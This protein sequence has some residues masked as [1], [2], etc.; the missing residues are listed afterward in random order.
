M[1]L[2]KNAK[3][4][5]PVHLIPF[6]IYKRKILMKQYFYSDFRPL[7]TIG[8]SLLSYA[9]SIL[10]LTFMVEILRLNWCKQVRL[11]KTVDAFIPLTGGFLGGFA[12]LLESNTRYIHIKM[13]SL[14]N[15]V[16]YC[17]KIFRNTC[18]PD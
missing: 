4:Y 6:I 11:R 17:A 9:K 14:R 1:L 16:E 10:F 8:K 12:L 7:S 18:K 5:L 15:Y 13:K 3:V 2:A